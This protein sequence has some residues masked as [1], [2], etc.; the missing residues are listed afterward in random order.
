MPARTPNLAE[1]RDIQ[2]AVSKNKLNEALRLM[3][4]FPDFQRYLPLLQRDLT[5]IKQE[6]IKGIENPSLVDKKRL[7]A[8]RLLGLLE[9]YLPTE[10][11]EPAPAGTHRGRSDYT[12][13]LT[14]A[15]A[16]YLRVTTHFRGRGE[17]LAKI[18]ALLAA[19]GQP[20]AI[21]GGGGNGKTTVCHRAIANWLSAGPDHR[22]YVVQVEHLSSF[23]LFLAALASLAGLDPDRTGEEQLP[24][25]LAALAE[26]PS[27][28]LYL[29]N[30]ESIQEEPQALALLNRIDQAGN[31]RL[32]CS[33]RI[34]LAGWE[35]VPLD[36][37]SEADGLELFQLEWHRKSGRTLE[38]PLLPAFVKTELGNHPLSIELTASHAAEYLHLSDLIDDWRE[39][40]AALLARFAGREGEKNDNFYLSLGLSL[41][42]LANQP[43]AR[44]LLALCALFQDGLDGA[45]QT[46][47]RQ[48]DVYT[49]RDRI[50]LFERN[51]VRL[52][53]ANKLELL[54]PVARLI[55][56]GLRQESEELLDEAQLFDDG[57]A[58]ACS[59]DYPTQAR[60]DFLEYFV[61][62]GWEEERLFRVHIS[63]FNDYQKIP[64]R[65]RKLLSDLKIHP[66]WKG[67][68]RVLSYILFFL[69]QLEFILG[70]NDL[71]RDHFTKADKLYEKIGDELGRA[72]VT[73]NLGTLE[74]MLGHNDLARDHFTEAGKLHEK[75]GDELGRANVIFNLG[76]LEFRLGQNDLARDHF[77]KA[78]KL[79]EKI[80]HELGRAN[81]LFNLG[82]LEFRL[83]QNDLARDHFTKAGKLYE[84]IGH[85]LGRVNV[86]CILGELE[87]MLGQND[88]ARDYFTEAG[89]LYEKTGDELGRA[90]VLFNLGELEFRLGHNDLARDH[91]TE[92]GKLYEKIGSEQGRANT[93]HY[94]A[95]LEK[96]EYNYEDAKVNWNKALKLYRMI[97]SPRDIADTQLCLSELAEESVDPL[98]D[99]EERLAEVKVLINAYKLDHL[100]ERYAALAPGE[101]GAGEEE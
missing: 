49:A 69:G 85:E 18:A 9:P 54:P 32:L 73:R 52:N 42:R 24:Q 40:D 39:N 94:V 5:E 71:A 10:E 100:R 88:L 64:L 31:L 43:G 21:Y 79:Y 16:G 41:R 46:S 22:A 72:N 91:F 12:R 66:F 4:V 82:A 58:I 57:F 19:P 37:L 76:K 81:V 44:R 27:G 87:F 67:N 77:T 99:R 1:Y 101:D 26:L 36:V 98:P 11:L 17:K 96:A 97:Q 55:R 7:V 53:E 2:A 47:L 78:G 34:R 15:A 20:I 86:T 59:L 84:K 75:I 90:N 38:D 89:K 70:H 92:A 95:Q 35:E 65:S 6:Q 30:L 63:L 48:A 23:P 61:Y 8:D 62:C 28:L 80:G 45:M 93:F 60:L 25:L 83:G 68:D 56:S 13:L 74:F 3:N 33:T 51:L 50:L 29:D 14:D